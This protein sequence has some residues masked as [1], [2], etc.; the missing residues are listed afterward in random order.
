MPG[1]HGNGWKRGTPLVAV[2]T[3]TGTQTTLVALNELIDPQLGLR[4]G[5][6]YSVAV[7]PSGR[8]AFV[9]LNAGPV[10]PRS[11]ARCSS[12]WSTCRRRAIA[13]AAPGCVA[14]PWR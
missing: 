1:A 4:A 10:A 11:S 3:D 13:R 8:L 6:S 14:T 7:D 9:T 12:P 5:G 2:D